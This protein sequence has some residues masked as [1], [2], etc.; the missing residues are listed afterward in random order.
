MG[1]NFHYIVD[2]GVNYPSP[3]PEIKIMGLFLE[4]PDFMI[5]R[6]CFLPYHYDHED[7]FNDFVTS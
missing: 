1:I 6:Y 4:F 3:F 5:Q 2:P 7:V